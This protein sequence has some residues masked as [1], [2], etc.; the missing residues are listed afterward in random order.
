[1]LLLFF[2]LSKIHF[3]T[4]PQLRMTR[5]YSLSSTLKNKTKKKKKKRQR[6]QKQ[7]KRYSIEIHVVTMM[8]F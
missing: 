7:S 5:I 8:C 4:L 6:K 3:I 2:V 1:M